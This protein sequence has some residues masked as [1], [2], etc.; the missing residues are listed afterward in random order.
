MSFPYNLPEA[1]QLSILSSM[2]I[3]DLCSS[4]PSAL[5]MLYSH[6]MRSLSWPRPKLKRRNHSHAPC[7]K[8]LGFRSCRMDNW[9]RR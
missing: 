6:V 9:H 1:I 4:L 8:V 3:V 2:G 5:G 7:D